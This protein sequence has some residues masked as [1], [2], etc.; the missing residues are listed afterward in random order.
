MEAKIVEREIE[1]AEGMSGTF[2]PKSVREINALWNKFI[3]RSSEIKNSK[4]GL[5]K[6]IRQ[7][8]IIRN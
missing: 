3:P 5:V 2:R 4:A 1:Y 6:K 7:A 8:Q